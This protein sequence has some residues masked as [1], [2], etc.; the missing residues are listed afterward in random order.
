MMDSTRTSLHPKLGCLILRCQTNICQ[1]ATETH[2]DIVFNGFGQWKDR[3]LRDQYLAANEHLVQHRDLSP[4]HSLSAIQYLTIPC[5][6]IYTS[7]VHRKA[8]Y[9]S[10]RY[11]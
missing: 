4:A 7:T 2:T 9:R 5:Q 10:S 8:V 11:Q 1:D 6:Q 3:H